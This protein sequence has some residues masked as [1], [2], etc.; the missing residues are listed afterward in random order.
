VSTAPAE[1]VNIQLI[2]LSEKQVG[3]VG[4]ECKALEEADT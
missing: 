2:R 1:D 4:Y 3:F